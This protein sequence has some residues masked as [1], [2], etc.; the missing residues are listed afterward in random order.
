MDSIQI[1]I[2]GGLQGRQGYSYHKEFS[3]TIFI[4]PQESTS[5]STALIYDG[6]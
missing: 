2:I 4:Y 6:Y 1:V 5:S 3:N